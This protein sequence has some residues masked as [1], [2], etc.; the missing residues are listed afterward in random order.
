MKNEGN[1]RIYENSLARGI[2]NQE[3]IEEQQENKIDNNSEGV[4]HQGGSFLPSM[5]TIKMDLKNN[6]NTTHS[7]RTKDH[8]LEG[9]K[10]QEGYFLL[11]M[12]IFF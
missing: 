10:H 11:G 6:R 12:G 8:N 1:S 3:E 9:M 4:Q 2:K 7:S 5:R